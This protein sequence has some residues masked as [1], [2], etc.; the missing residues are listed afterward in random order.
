MTAKHVG[1]YSMD[2]E[3]FIIICPPSF[4][5]SAGYMYMDKRA[6]AFLANSKS[7]SEESAYEVIEPIGAVPLHPMG[8][9]IE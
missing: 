3:A 6:T 4:E 5:G 8:A 7:V 9:L 2:R 1:A